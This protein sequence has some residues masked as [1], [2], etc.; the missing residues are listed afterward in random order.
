MFGF[1]DAFSQNKYKLYQGF[2]NQCPSLR[3]G[4]TL[5]NMTQLD[6]DQNLSDFAINLCAQTLEIYIQWN[7]RTNI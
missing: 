7:I 6:T 1:E 3:L 5:K 2:F 4:I